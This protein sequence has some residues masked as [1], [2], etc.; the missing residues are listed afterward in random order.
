AQVWQMR[1]DLAARLHPG[2]VDGGGEGVLEVACADGTR[3]RLGAYYT[4]GMEGSE[5]ADAAGLCWATYGLEFLAQQP[6]WERDPITYRWAIA[7]P[8]DTW[9]PILPIKVR[10]ADVIGQGMTIANPGSVRSWPVW[11][12]TGPLDGSAAMRPV[13]TSPQW[14]FTATLRQGEQSVI[15][16]RAPRQ[17]ERGRADRDRHPAAPQNGAGW[18]RRQHVR[19]AHRRQRAVAARPRGQRHRRRADGPV[20]RLPSGV[21]DHSARADRIG[22]QGGRVVAAGQGREPG[23]HRR[24]RGRL[25]AGGYRAPSCPR[26]VE[27]RPGSGRAGC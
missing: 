1:R 11:T 12:I 23:P 27:D 6:Y 4:G 17:T 3:W 25:R 10:D 20:G 7:P 18:H 8:T 16:T 24:H 26:G 5:G 2:V 21:G 13:T 14:A 15:D 9:L 22:E 19:R